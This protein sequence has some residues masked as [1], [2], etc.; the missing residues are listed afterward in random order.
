VRVSRILAGLALVA[1][2]TDSGSSGPP[3]S[4]S[5]TSCPA[6]DYILGGG[7]VPLPSPVS[8]AQPLLDEGDASDSGAL[9]DAASDAGDATQDGGDAGDD[10]PRDASSDGAD[11]GPGD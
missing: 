9:G 8:D 2:C 1:G 10:A 6:G 11:A 4:G 7:C 5:G 3:A